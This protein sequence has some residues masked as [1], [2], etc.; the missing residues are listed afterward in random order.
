MVTEQVAMLHIHSGDCAARIASGIFGGTH[1]VWSDNLFEGALPRADWGDPEWIAARAEALADY[2]GGRER[3]ADLLRKR[4]ARLREAL[5]ACS[6][7]TLWFDSC[8]YDMMLLFSFLAVAGDGLFPRIPVWL[9]CGEVRRDGTRFAGYG[10]L[11]EA[12]MRAQYAGRR[13]VTEAMRHDAL[14]CWDAFTSPS[15]EDWRAMAE[16]EHELTPFL[17]PAAARFCEQLPDARGLNRL[18][19]EI[20]TVLDD[21]C[22]EL[23]P[24][25]RAVCAMEERP[26]FG[27]AAVWQ[28]L[29]RMAAARVPLA[30]LRGPAERIPVKVFPPSDVPFRA[31]EW[32][33]SLTQAGKD[34]LA[35]RGP[36]WECERQV[37]NVAVGQR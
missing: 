25:F 9:V 30:E 13:R 3:A 1:L 33:V 37:G 21:G 27:D 28:T 18:E 17:A 22:T 11:D 7:V 16:K 5:A 35:G 31:D 34:A 23:V 2:L 10:E 32:R 20:L 14:E 15:P 26:F 19:A 8:L 12:E 29:N 36:A 4:H 6:E 24:L